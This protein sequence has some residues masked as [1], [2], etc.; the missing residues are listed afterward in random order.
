MTITSTKCTG[1]DVGVGVH[2]YN[3]KSNLFCFDMA[4]YKFCNFSNGCAGHTHTAKNRPTMLFFRNLSLLFVQIL[5]CLFLVFPSF[6]FRIPLFFVV[7]SFFLFHLLCSICLGEF[8]SFHFLHIPLR[9]FLIGCILVKSC[10][11]C[12]VL[13]HRAMKLLTIEPGRER[14]EK[15]RC[16]VYT[17]L[18]S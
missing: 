9:M 8:H 15:G 2:T 11:H 13:D 17:Q 12:T 1:T 4:W 7:S 14:G 18:Q 3:R 16:F 6:V 10:L 5:P